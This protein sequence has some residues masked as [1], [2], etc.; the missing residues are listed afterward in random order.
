MQR[1]EMGS[2]GGGRDVEDAAP[3]RYSGQLCTGVANEISNSTG[4]PRPSPTAFVPLSPSQAKRRER[5][6]REGDNRFVNHVLA[7]FVNHLITLNSFPSRIG[8]PAIDGHFYFLLC[9]CLQRGDGIGET[10]HSVDEPRFHRFP[11]L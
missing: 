3:Y 1:G 5:P 7:H 4:G 9:H 8:R 10:A 2:N 6:H 11:A